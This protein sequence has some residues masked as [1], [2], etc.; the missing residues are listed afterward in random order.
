VWSIVGAVRLA[1]NPSKGRGLVV[2][3]LLLAIAAGTAA[4]GLRTSAPPPR[5]GL[6]APDQPRPL[7]ESGPPG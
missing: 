6:A 3:V 5:S 4:L 2:A 7:A 1:I